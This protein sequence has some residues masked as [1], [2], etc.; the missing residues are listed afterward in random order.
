MV[1]VIN[2]SEWGVVWYNRTC[3]IDITGVDCILQSHFLLTKSLGMW[4]W[5][6]QGWSRVVSR[7][8]GLKADHLADH[9]H[10]VYSGVYL[11]AGEIRV[12]EETIVI[13]L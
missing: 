12:R 2:C 7:P 5:R 10:T 4:Q 3:I 9:A 13:L 1:A 8:P 6:R 11:G